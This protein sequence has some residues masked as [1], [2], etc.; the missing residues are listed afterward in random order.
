[1]PGAQ[2]NVHL[3][4]GHLAQ[5]GKDAGVSRKP[6]E[7]SLDGL[8]AALLAFLI[9]Q[10]GVQHIGRGRVLANKAKAAG[11]QVPDGAKVTRRGDLASAGYGGAEN[12]Q[13]RVS[14]GRRQARGGLPLRLGA[15]LEHALRL[16]SVRGQVIC[17][18]KVFA[19][20]LPE[21]L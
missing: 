20:I 4:V 17:K 2:G 19:R 13:V 7:G 9:P 10:Q 6:L 3:V 11:R 8:Q 21:G 18:R 15:V 5:V 14:R 12:S 16:D 1:M